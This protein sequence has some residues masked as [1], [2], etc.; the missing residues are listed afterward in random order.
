MVS[1]MLALEL[2]GDGIIVV[3]MNPDWVQTDMGGDTGIPYTKGKRGQDD[4]YNEADQ[5]R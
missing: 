3:A 2:S 4:S 5:R 1:K